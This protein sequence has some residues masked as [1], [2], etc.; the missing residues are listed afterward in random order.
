MQNIVK[1]HIKQPISCE[2]C[3]FFQTFADY[4]PFFH[5]SEVWNELLATS[6]FKHSDTTTN[7]ENPPLA[8]GENE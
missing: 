8:D 3:I 5:F 2:S 4:R 7:T 1:F 6:H